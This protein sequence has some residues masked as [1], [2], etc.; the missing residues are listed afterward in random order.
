MLHT[1]YSKLCILVLLLISEIE[2]TRKQTKKP[3]RQIKRSRQ[4]KSQK[5]N[6]YNKAPNAAADQAFDLGVRGRK[7]E[8]NTA[9]KVATRTITRR[10]G[11]AAT[12]ATVTVISSS[13]TTRTVSIT[14]TAAPTATHRPRTTRRVTLTRTGPQTIRVDTDSDSEHIT[15]TQIVPTTIT[16]PE[17][18]V[19][20]R[21]DNTTTVIQVQTTTVSLP[22]TTTIT[23]IVTEQG[24]IETVYIGTSSLIT[25]TV[26]EIRT[27]S[28][29]VVTVTVDNLTPML[30]TGA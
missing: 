7:I 4:P 23:E 12:T 10:P 5:A 17:V 28:I 20:Q 2:A 19:T 25:T 29:G 27:I 9:G 8:E 22:V 21:V 1:F 6:W 13:I 18:T 11:E 16:Q 30:Y 3:I 15:V 14:V 24:P 26:T